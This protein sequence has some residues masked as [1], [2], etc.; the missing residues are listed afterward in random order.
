MTDYT[1]ILINEDGVETD[2]DV[3][4]KTE[5]DAIIEAWRQYR[6]L[7]YVDNE[8][9]PDWTHPMVLTEKDFGR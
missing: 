5:E 2:W 3:V 7:F 4:A 8:Y 9:P 1:V 6:D